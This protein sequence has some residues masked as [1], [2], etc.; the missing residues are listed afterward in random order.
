MMHTKDLEHINGTNDEGY[1][2]CRPLIHQIL[3]ESKFSL[4]SG[5]R[6]AHRETNPYHTTLMGFK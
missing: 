5:G 2:S 6:A 3:V 4:E 1:F